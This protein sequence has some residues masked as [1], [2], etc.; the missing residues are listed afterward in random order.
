MTNK[1]AQPIVN[2]IWLLVEILSVSNQHI[3]AENKPNAPAINAEA[4][5]ANLGNN[6]GEWTNKLEKITEAATNN[7]Q[8]GITITQILNQTKAKINIT[9]KSI[10]AT[11]KASAILRLRLI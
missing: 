2:G 5:A 7:T 11:F 3:N 4:D 6:V 8:I 9:N 10:P 1:L